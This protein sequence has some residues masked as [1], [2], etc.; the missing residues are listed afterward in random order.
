LQKGS[1]TVIETLQLLK[2]KNLL[3]VPTYDP[4]EKKWLGLVDTLDIM[5]LITAMSDLKVLIDAMSKKEVD[6]RDFIAHE[7]KIVSEEPITSAI[8]I[9]DRNPWCPVS[10]FLPL[11]SLMDMFSKDVNL[12]RV[13]V[14]D[15]DGEVVGFLSQI[16]IIDFLYKNIQNFPFASWK[17]KDYFKE[18]KPVI[19]ITSDKTALEGYHL[20]KMNQISGIAVVDSDGKLVGCLS[21]SDLKGSLEVNLFDDL[22]LPIELY[23]QKRSLEFSSELNRS[24]ISCSLETS[25]YELLH[26]LSTNQIHRIFCLDSF[27]QPIGVLALCD[28]ISMMN[29]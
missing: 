5:S 3:C 24:P 13:P 19:S 9:S 10:Q 1:N 6:W 12:H 25:I 7:L 11:H 17:V 18:S 27:G 23:L 15:N 20:I 8:N 14:V 4:L 26:K 22:Y 2:S 16:G 21:A 28:I 29:L